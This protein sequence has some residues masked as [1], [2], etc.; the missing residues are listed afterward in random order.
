[1]VAQPLLQVDRLSKEFVIRRGGLFQRAKESVT[2]V[3]GVSFDVAAGEILSIAGEPGS[4]KTTLARSLVQLIRP[5][6]GRVIFQGVD[7]VQKNQGALRPI[8]RRLQF[9]F[10]DPRS[11]LNPR[12]L[13]S[14]VMLEPLEAQHIGGAEEKI[15]IAH[16]ALRQVGLNSLLF[17][18][19]LTNLSVG[20]RQRVALAR[21]L[22]LRPVMIVCD[23]PARTLS[24]GVAESFFRLMADL[25]RK[26]GIA[27][28]WI[29]GSIQPAAAHADRLGI[30]CRGQLVEIGATSD[31]LTSPQHPY[32]QRWTNETPA[33]LAAMPSADANTCRYHPDCPHVMPRCRERAPAM[34][35]TPTA[36][37][38][39]CYLFD[40]AISL[41]HAHGG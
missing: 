35:A 37:P 5:T 11:S 8:R 16:Q 38:A 4:G 3:H 40:D 22:A 20:E 39:A 18:R 24:P 9:L 31:V 21:A 14:N 26:Q 27:F 32:T 41:P 28:V 10:S 13:V 23:D 34:F 30:L 33:P 12:S 29:V 36:H 25:R 7:L 19:P 17:D 2:A 15:S 6:T 1:M